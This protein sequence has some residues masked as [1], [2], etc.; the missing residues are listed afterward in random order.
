ML[1]AIAS[2]NY[3][4]V[5]L[6]RIETFVSLPNSNFLYSYNTII[7]KKKKKKKKI[8]HTGDIESLDRCG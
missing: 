6:W 5:I 2:G 4:F 8:P 1:P 3:I 7:M